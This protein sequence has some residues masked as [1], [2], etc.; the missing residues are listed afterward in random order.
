M[1]P[2]INSLE[3]ARAFR[4]GK[5]T[6]RSALEDALSK[7]SHFLSA[8]RARANDSRAPRYSLAAFQLVFLFVY[9]YICSPSAL[10]ADDSI[11]LFLF[12][13][14]I[15]DIMVGQDES[16]TAKEALLRWAQRTTAKYPGV[17][18]KDFTSSWKDGLAFNAI[19]H[20]NRCFLV[21]FSRSVVQPPRKRGA[22]RAP[23]SNKTR[24]STDRQ[25]HLLA[26]ESLT[27][28]MPIG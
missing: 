13:Q 28:R 17:R 3:T 18:V 22:Q 21:Q 8:R 25:R 26:V 24:C 2:G 23:Q 11:A 27:R 4:S 20:R 10:D 7:R 12:A 16:L 9:L 19:I 5:K 1:T 14:Q 6:P 15:S